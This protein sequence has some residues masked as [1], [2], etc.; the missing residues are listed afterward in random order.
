MGKRR[1]HDDR[2]E[3][4]GETGGGAMPTDED[5]R[6]VAAKLHEGEYVERYCPNCGAKVEEGE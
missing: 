3:K 2:A 6:E 5:R 4:S 1:D